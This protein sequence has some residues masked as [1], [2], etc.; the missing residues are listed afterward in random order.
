MAINQNQFRSQPE[1]SSSGNTLLEVILELLAVQ[2]HIN[3]LE[4]QSV[5][6]PT[7]P[8]S[9]HRRL[10]FLQKKYMHLRE[11]VHNNCVD[12]FQAKI[13][14]LEANLARLLVK[15]SFDPMEELCCAVI[16]SNIQ[17]YQ[18]LLS[19]KTRFTTL[20]TAEALLQD[21]DRWWYLYE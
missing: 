16:Q 13:E 17:Y 9:P 11:L 4:D 3:A 10:Q 2:D 12:F 21:R 7:G 1:D 15:Q 8:N 18:S 14:E 20:P 19:Y 6:S 5:H